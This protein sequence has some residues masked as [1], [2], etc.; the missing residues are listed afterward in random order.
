[1]KKRGFEVIYMVD[2]ID[3]YCAQQLREYDG[4]TL[5]SVTKEG[6]ELPEDDDEKKRYVFG[7]G[8]ICVG[9]NCFFVGLRSKRPNLRACAR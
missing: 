2:P 3:E 4:K 1:M 7:I 9:D 8:C 5:M 6:L